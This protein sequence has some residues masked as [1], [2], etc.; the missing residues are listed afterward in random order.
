MAALALL[1]AACN[2]SEEDKLPANL[3]EAEGTARADDSV[4]SPPPEEELPDPAAEA[5]P[6][7]LEE[8]TADP[9]EPG[10]ERA[11][12]P[13]M[14]EPSYACRGALTRV[15][16]LICSDSELAALDRQLARDYARA[17]DES[18]PE[19][20][21]RLVRLGRRYLF[22]RDRCQTRECVVGAYRSYLR[23]IATI[24]DGPSR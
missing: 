3:A 6:P 24:M 16:M 17:I 8:P 11:A 14:A 22:D 19:Q 5:P 10:A 7:Q 4:L 18:S 13:P 1:L 2:P 15:E 9:L 20:E 23:D 21:E 12:A